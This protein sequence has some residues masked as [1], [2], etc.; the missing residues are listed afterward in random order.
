MRW[1]PV[2]EPKKS[3]SKRVDSL[4]PPSRIVSV[5]KLMRVCLACASKSVPS[6]DAPDRRASGHVEVACRV[7]L[8]QFAVGRV[9]PQAVDLG[10]TRQHEAGAGCGIRQ[11]RARLDRLRRR[12]GR[13]GSDRA[14]GGRCRNGGRR[15]LLLRHELLD[16]LLEFR[17]ASFEFL[18]LRRLGAG[19]R[20]CADQHDAERD[21]D[22]AAQ[23]VG[24]TAQV[25]NVRHGRNPPDE[26]CDAAIVSR[27]GARGYSPL[28]AVEN[29]WIDQV[30][31]V[32]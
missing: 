2:I 19:Q 15:H 4:S 6:L 1:S 22:R 13:C 30:S 12:R 9:R 10:V 29:R 20:G 26:S 18:F 28:V 25:L 7:V 24:W 11:D 31:R 27:R 14:C 21:C 16:E 8:R 17:D 5:P 32:T 23:G 3:T